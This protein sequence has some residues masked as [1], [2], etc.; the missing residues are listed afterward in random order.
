MT[1]RTLRR[2]SVLVLVLL[3]LPAL[4]APVSA[5]SAADVLERVLERYEASIDGVQDYTVTQK[6]MGFTT[7]T[8]F[9]KREI[10]GHPVFVPAEPEGEGEN[11]VP[12]GWGNP[13][14][15]LP[16]LASRATIAGH[17]S[18][19]GRDTWIIEVTDL[20]DLDFE[21]MTPAGVGGEFRPTGMRFQVGTEDD[22][23]RQIHVTGEVASEGSEPRPVEMTASLLD[24]RTVDGMPYPFQARI[25]VQGLAGAMSREEQAAARQQLQ[26]LRERMANMPE[27]QREMMEQMMG[28]QLEN[29]EKM[30]EGG[31][32]DVTVEATSVEV[33][34]GGG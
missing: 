14:R 8:R 30:V 28:S 3:G 21:G 31:P 18:V 16:E 32:V 27:Q 7:T 10:G 2:A 6:V 4:A 5:Q 24:Y 22:L 23:L 25:R 34:R 26:Q 13:Y 11:P 20:E 9:V 33:N 15:M 19:E 17:G 29:L 1:R 12:E